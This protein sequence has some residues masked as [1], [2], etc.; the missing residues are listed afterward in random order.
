MYQNSRSKLT[1]SIFI[2]ILLS[3]QLVAQEATQ[4]FMRS[5]GKIYVVVAVIALIFIGIVLYL[6]RLDS[7][8]SKLEKIIKEHGEN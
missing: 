2:A 6:T 1:L 4:D 7:K 8:I 3:N 5:T